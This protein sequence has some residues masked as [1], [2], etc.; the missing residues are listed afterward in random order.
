MNEVRALDVG[1]GSLD[2]GL[3]GRG[4][5]RCK[6]PEARTLYQAGSRKNEAYVTGAERMRGDIERSGSSQSRSRRA[7][8]T[9]T[10]WETTE[11]FEQRCVV[12]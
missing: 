6:N 11:G 12:M 10:E 8:W 4:K 7:C 9:V 3:P 2:K 1:A 5:S